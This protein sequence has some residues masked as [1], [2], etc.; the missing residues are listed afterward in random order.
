[1]QKRK[2]STVSITSRHDVEMRPLDS[3]D[4][5]ELPKAI[6]EHLQHCVEAHRG[7]T[8]AD[9]DVIR[10]LWLDLRPVNGDLLSAED[11]LNVVDEAAALGTKF[12]VACVGAR[13]AEHPEI[14]EVAQ[15]A[16]KTYRLNF[17]IHMT[18]PSLSDDEVHQLAQL[19]R[20]LTHLFAPTAALP[21]LHYVQEAG[22]NL[23]PAEV[24]DG[25]HSGSC[26][27][28]QNL[29]YVGPKGVIYSCGLVSGI[30]EFCLGHIL[31]KP[32]EQLIEE[33]R[34]PKDT[35]DHLAHQHNRCSGCPPRLFKHLQSH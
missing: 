13:P 26:H 8:L 29:I 24:C 11:W 32:L 30:E 35:P 12:I 27:L 18:G 3:Q 28:P 17:G 22:I 23:L 10:Y 25:E 16:Q 31:E 4:P 21:D 34:A 9:K 5:F 6:A 2:P 14:W 20:E 1:M 33:S 19:D 15:W 7:E